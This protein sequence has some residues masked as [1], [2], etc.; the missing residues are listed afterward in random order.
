MAL[1]YDGILSRDEIS[2]CLAMIDKYRFVVEVSKFP[3]YEWVK[4]NLV[5]R[6]WYESDDAYPE[7]VVSKRTGPRYGTVPKNFEHGPRDKDGYFI[8]GG[9]IFVADAEDH[10]R[11]VD[12]LPK[13]VV[14]ANP[15]KVM[16]TA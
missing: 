7:P 4:D 13:L 1:I 14:N 16:L 15:F 6:S 8:G 5:E 3:S 2:G 10:K 12:L 11:I 9:F